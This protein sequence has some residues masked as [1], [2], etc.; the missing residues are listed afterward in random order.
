MCDQQSRCSVGICL[1]YFENADNYQATKCETEWS[2]MDRITADFSIT[3]AT[4]TPG[5]HRRDLP[6]AAL[7]VEVYY[8]RG[9]GGWDADDQDYCSRHPEEEVGR[10]EGAQG[11][12]R[13]CRGRSPPPYCSPWRTQTSVPDLHPT[14]LVAI[15]ARG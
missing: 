15:K 8:G 12:D 4:P 9:E 10:A 5:F 13:I 6:V 3:K 14:H 11:G 7:A 1:C 2:S